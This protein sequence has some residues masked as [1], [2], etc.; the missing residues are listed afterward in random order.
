MF[1]TI[2][3]YKAGIIPVQYRRVPC[4]KS[5]GVR[6]ELRG[7]PYFLMV[8]VYNVANAGD[9][10]RVSIKGSNTG[11][12]PLIHNWGQVWNTGV[13]LVGHDLSFWVTTSDRKTLRFTSVAPFNWQFGQTFESSVNF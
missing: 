11:W 7:N 8:L 4:V 1:T 10:L 6:F 13:N 2:A 9:V 3:I 5:G 12:I